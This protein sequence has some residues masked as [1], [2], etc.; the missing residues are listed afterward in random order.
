MLPTSSLDFWALECSWQQIESKENGN[1]RKRFF[2]IIVVVYG[3]IVICLLTLFVVVGMVLINLND[4]P[5][6]L[7]NSFNKIPKAMGV[8]DFILLFIFVYI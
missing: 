8:I 2:R 3:L 5:N 1:D 4:Y 6:R 7:P